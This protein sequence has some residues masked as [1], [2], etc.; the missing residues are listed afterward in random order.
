MKA[1]SDSLQPARLA[2]GAV[3][4]LVLAVVVFTALLAY[5]DAERVVAQ[6]ERIGLWVLGPVVLLTLCNYA[7][8]WVKWHFLLA[9]IGVTGLGYRD[10]ILLF[11]AGMAMVLSPGKVGELLK[12]YY[13]RE[14][15]GTPVT[16]SAPVIFVERL[17]DGFA[18]LI[19]AS[20]GF[21]VHASLGLGLVPVAAGLAA[22]LLATTWGRPARAVLRLGQRWP[23]LR[24]PSARAL[25]LYESVQELVRPRVLLPCVA[26]GVISWSGEA[27]AFF[28]I[29]AQVGLPP[30]PGLALDA[31]FTLA[32]A[33]L[34][35]SASMLPGGL[36]ASEASIAGLLQVLRALPADQAV[37][38]TLLIRVGTLWLGVLVGLVSLPLLLLAVRRRRG[39]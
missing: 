19:L 18:M 25:A 38:A 31:A 22:L 1:A 24:G 3:L 8:R 17:S 39:G 29:L 36:G 33:V 13:L 7:L 23:R 26:L 12:S 35:G 15:A 21:A 30:T 32:S 6:L 34:V 28:V 20:G 16:R 27:L 37:A 2:R 11:C 5:G 9:C 4:A 10:S 14:L